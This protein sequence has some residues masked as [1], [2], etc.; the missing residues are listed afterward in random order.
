MSVQ[1]VSREQQKRMDE[2][3]YIAPT[4]AAKLL[5]VHVS[6]I[7]RW[8]RDGKL[9]M[10]RMPERAVFVRKSQIAALLK[11]RAARYN[12]PANLDHIRW[13]LGEEITT[14]CVVC[15]TPIPLSKDRCVNCVTIVIDHTHG[16][17]VQT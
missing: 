14:E 8:A 17:E 13:L 6:S 11:E 1:G 10:V 2:E 4:H 12:Q 5:G 16:T 9:G 15:R 3:G 7:Y